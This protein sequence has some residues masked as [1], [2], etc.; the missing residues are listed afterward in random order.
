MKKMKIIL[1]TILVLSLINSYVF[2][3]QVLLRPT[4][5]D[6]DRSQ[7]IFRGILVDKYSNYETPLDLEKPD[8]MSVFTTYLFKVTEIFKGTYVDEEIEV[9]MYGGCIE[10]ADYCIE[11]SNDYYYEINDDAL[12][13]L[14]LNKTYGHFQSLNFTTAYKVE[15]SI[16][17]LTSEGSLRYYYENNNEGKTIRKDVLTLQIVKKLIKDNNEQKNE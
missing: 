16:E 17:V 10:G 5:E 7:L 2:S 13:F 6:I 3:G 12:M 8:N 14:N 15:G 9:K 11:T 1:Y 4:S